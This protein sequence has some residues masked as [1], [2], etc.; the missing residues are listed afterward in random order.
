MIPLTSR[1]ER[2]YP[3]EAHVQLRGKLGKVL[4]SQLTT[5]DKQR[6][7]NRDGVITEKEMQRVEEAIRAQLDL[8]GG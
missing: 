5:V 1:V 6:L 2:I 3:S 8:S 7:L 4:A